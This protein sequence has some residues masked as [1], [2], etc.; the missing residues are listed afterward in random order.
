MENAISVSPSIPPLNPT[1]WRL[2]YYTTKGQIGWHTD[3]H[4][5][6][7]ADQQHTVKVDCF[8]IIFDTAQEPVISVTLGNSG[9]FDYRP[10]GS[11]ESQMKSL[12]LNSGDVI[13]F[14]GPS[15][16]VLHRVTKIFPNTK[17]VGLN[18][19]AKYN[20]GRFNFAFYNN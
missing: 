8:F 13:I 19:G 16:M 17:P 12:K 7:A 2:N 14:G 4:P 18:L 9:N 15:R 20:H 10:L 5:N 1:V 11:D 6:V 3:R